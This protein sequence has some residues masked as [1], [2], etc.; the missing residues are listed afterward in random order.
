MDWCAAFRSSLPSRIL[1]LVLYFRYH[2]LLCAALPCRNACFSAEIECVRAFV[3]SRIRRRP[4][5]CG[6]HPVHGQ[7]RHVVGVGWRRWSVCA[8][9][10]SCGCTSCNSCQATAAGPV[11]SDGCGDRP[12]FSDA[13]AGDDRNSHRVSTFVFIICTVTMTTVRRLYRF[14]VSSSCC[15]QRR[16]G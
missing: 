15:R 13:R 10:G 8:S 4:W 2:S 1:V 9:Y 5:R 3:T 14:A 7:G 11:S 16:A 12:R 6:R